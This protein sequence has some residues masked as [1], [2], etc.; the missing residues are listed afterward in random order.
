MTLQ[1]DLA[2]MTI[3][4]LR[5]DLDTGAVSAH[6]ILDAALERIRQYESYTNSFITLVPEESL[7][8]EAD[9]ADRICKLK[10][11]RLLTGI[12][13]AI[14]DNMYVQGIRC[15]GGSR[16]LE[17]FFPET[18]A[19]AV[20]R[21][22]KAGGIIL[23]KANLHEFARGA[24]NVNP[25][26]GT[27]HNPWN[28]AHI[29]GGSSGGSAVAVASGYA[30]CATGTDTGGS[31]RCPAALCGIVGLK[32]TYDKIPRQGVLPLSW[33]LD[34]VGPMTRCVED[35]KL[36]TEIMSNKKESKSDKSQSGLNENDLNGI[37]VGMPRKIFHFLD[38]KVAGQ[39][40][41][42]VDNLREMGCT[43]TEVSIPHFEFVRP[44]V[45]A[46]TMA[47]GTSV[48]E[49]WA[50]EKFHLYS[51][52]LQRLIEI[53][54]SIP[55]THYLRALRFRG[56][57]TQSMKNMFRE[58]DILALP[59]VPTVAPLI[60]KEIVEV[61]GESFP[62]LKAMSLYLSMFNFTGMPALTLPAGFVDGL[63]VA[64]EL[65]ADHWNEGLLF[66]VGKSFEIVRKYRV[67]KPPLTSAPQG[68]M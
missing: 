55:A 59:T 1:S 65:A 54:Y 14:K 48:H 15:T 19:P 38:S 49:K 4:A 23:G 29:S 57:F 63:P 60:G 17:S 56:E 32:P 33:S 12:P 53:G 10:E 35:A 34:H 58:V 43:I 41:K 64:L 5:E 66:R 40:E 3:T 31:I 37:R 13:I 47:E 68:I 50:K 67:E 21:L 2:F 18:D 39:F 11:S 44:A 62:I 9:E 27:T 25:A 61:G 16:V 45:L 20:E 8:K 30:Y 24:T 22:K 51:R 52:E 26:F 28:L 42:A 6:E 46:I 7:R 36:L